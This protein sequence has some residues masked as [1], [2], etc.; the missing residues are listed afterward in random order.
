M[1]A[2][3]A[4]GSLAIL[5]ACLGLFAAAVAAVGGWLAHRSL[6]DCYPHQDAYGPEEVS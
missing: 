4:I 3:A 1:K 2:L 5:A 6:P